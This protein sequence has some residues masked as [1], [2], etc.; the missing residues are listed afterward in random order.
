MENINYA[1]AS[2]QL[3]GYFDLGYIFYISVQLLKQKVYIEFLKTYNNSYYFCLE[4]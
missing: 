4:E 3:H 1:L 2:N